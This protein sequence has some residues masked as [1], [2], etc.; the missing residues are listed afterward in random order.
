MSFL[1]RLAWPPPSR[2]RRSPDQ[3]PLDADGANDVPSEAKTVADWRRRA[4]VAAAWATTVL[5]FLLVWF[6][7]VSPNELSRLTPGAFLRIPVEGLVIVA[8]ALVVPPR[9]RPFVAIPI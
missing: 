3:E 7:L 6:A 8:V 9:A 1:S 2:K 5:A 4:R